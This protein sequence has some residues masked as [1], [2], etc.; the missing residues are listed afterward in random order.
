M[1]TEECSQ[2]VKEWL[3]C[4]DEIRLQNEK[5]KSIK[6]KQKNLS[7]HIIHYMTI[8]NIE[9][10]TFE[11]GQLQKNVK[12]KMGTLSKKYVSTTLKEYFK[13][14]EHKTNELLETLL[15][16]REVK[17]ITSLKRKHE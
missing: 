12:K 8:N 11:G 10:F 17:E 16:N 2:Y 9:N 1:N 4:D 13:N 6:E 7:N 3:K 14:D 15:N 5:I